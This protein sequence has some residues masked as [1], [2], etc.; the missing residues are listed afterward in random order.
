MNKKKITLKADKN[1]GK[2]YLYLPS[3]ASMQR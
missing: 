2:G 1:G 3:S